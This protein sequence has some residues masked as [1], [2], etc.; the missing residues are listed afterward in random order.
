MVNVTLAVPEELHRIMKSHPE[1]KWSE[2]ARQ[3]IREYAEKL[4]LLDAITEK[5]RLTQGDVL[6]IDKRI[7]KDLLARYRTKRTS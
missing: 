7:K 6:E 4:Q 5:S 2:V 1:I 3:S